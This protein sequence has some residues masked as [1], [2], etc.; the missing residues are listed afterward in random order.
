MI[1]LIFINFFVH[2]I[3]QRLC[4]KSRQYWIFSGPFFVSAEVASLSAMIFFT[5]ISLS[6]SS[7][8]H[9]WNSYSVEPRVNL[10]SVFSYNP[11][12]SHPSKRL[13][14]NDIIGRISVLVSW[15]YAFV[16]RFATSPLACM[17]YALSNFEKKD[18]RLLAVYSTQLFFGKTFP[19]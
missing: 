3:L 15:A 17:G 7:N 16:Y 19:F 9:V 4:F 13:A 6:R 5:F 2:F 8:M 1:F 12:S 14:N 18:N 10:Q 11:F